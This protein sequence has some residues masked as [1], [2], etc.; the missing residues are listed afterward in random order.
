DILMTIVKK[1]PKG[2]SPSNVPGI[3]IGRKNSGMHYG[4]P[5]S[6]KKD[7]LAKVIVSTVEDAVKWFEDWLDGKYPDIEPE[8][9][10]W[11]L[12]N[13]WQLEDNDLYCFCKPGPCHGDVLVKKV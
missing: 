3:Y 12:E 2:M 9:R 4:N 10:K 13:L 7:S 8:R 5:A 1:I 6:H 11:I